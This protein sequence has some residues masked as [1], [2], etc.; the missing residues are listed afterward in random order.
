MIPKT[1]KTQEGI[2]FCEIGISISFLIFEFTC[3]NVTDIKNGQ[4][5]DVNTKTAL[6]YQPG[7]AGQ[8][9]T[10]NYN[11]YHPGPTSQGVFI[12]S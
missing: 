7:R 4:L 8:K 5:G 10:P 2:N 6:T 1:S 9:A 12:I 11:S 3:Y